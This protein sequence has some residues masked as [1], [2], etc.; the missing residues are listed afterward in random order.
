M[1]QLI[2]FVLIFSC[3]S[4]SAQETPDFSTKGTHY[5]GFHAGS[6]TGMGFSYRYVK[7]KWGVQLT[8]IPVFNND[9]FAMSN[10]FSLLYTIAEHEKV[11][12]FGYV[13]QHLLI[14]R[15]NE[16]VWDED[17][18]NYEEQRV[19]NYFWGTGIGAGVNYKLTD[20]LIMSTQ[21]G[22]G[23]YSTTWDNDRIF[24]LAAEW[25]IYYKF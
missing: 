11:D 25:G 1:R 23:M 5:A 12:V 6:T 8:T 3:A 22:Y 15:Q 24:F 4:L 2:C 9:F 14:S 16:W 19:S 13:G 20:Y 10:G 7:Q 21:V 17:Y 18:T